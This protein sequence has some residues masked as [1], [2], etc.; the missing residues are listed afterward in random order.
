MMFSFTEEQRFKQFV[1]QRKAK[2][3]NRLR[4]SGHDIAA[5]RMDAK[6]NAAG[7]VSEQVG[8]VSYLEYLQDL[9]TKI[10][11]DWDS[12]SSSLEDMRK[13][14]FSKDGCLINITI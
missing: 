14:L 8:G 3:E 9:E 7:W 13:S 5:A 12:I 2:M 1:S 4:G 11:Q 10:D 6:L